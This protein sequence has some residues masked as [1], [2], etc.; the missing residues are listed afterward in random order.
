VDTKEI[1]A[2]PDINFVAEVSSVF[3]LLCALSY[4]YKKSK[5]EYISGI[6]FVRSHYVMNDP[7]GERIIEFDNLRIELISYKTDYKNIKLVNDGST[8]SG[9]SKSKNN[10]LY[11]LSVK[12]PNYSL[13]K[14]WESFTDKKIKIILI[15]E[16]TGTYYNFSGFIYPVINFVKKLLIL[17]Q[18]S[19]V[20][21]YFLLKKKNSKLISN[22][23]I[24][25]DFV[26]LL[27]GKAEYLF[28]ID[29][30]YKNE[31]STGKYAIFISGLF[32]EMGLISNEEY[33]KK[34]YEIKTI[35]EKNDIKLL[36]KPY[37][38]EDLEKYNGLDI[39]L[40]QWEIPCE[41]LFPVIKPLYTL[42]FLSTS[43]L[44]GK[45]LYD[46]DSID[47]SIIF[48]LKEN[49][50]YYRKYEKMFVLFEDFILRSDTLEGFCKLI[51]ETL[52]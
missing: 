30:K 41:V 12:V 45:V 21:E 14:K 5:D 16:G 34:L 28:Q 27:S 39:E 24:I 9:V 22:S 35:L 23:D 10:T 25:P 18:G 17:M 49:E 32:V 11:I 4:A 19:G 29:S 6:I 46:I 1:K 50:S 33:K 47:L 48:N 40:L 26:D 38:S 31:N 3:H 43:M 15:D 37:Q 42:G 36:I 52:K 44:T 8:E 20:E 13:Y 2:S 51:N 7:I